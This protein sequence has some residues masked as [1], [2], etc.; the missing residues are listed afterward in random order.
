MH[1]PPGDLPSYPLQRV[2]SQGFRDECAVPLHK[3]GNSR[4]TAERI[5]ESMADV[6]GGLSELQ[7]TSNFFNDMKPS[8]RSGGSSLFRNLN[9][10]AEPTTREIR[11]A[12]SDAFFKQTYTSGQ[13]SARPL[14]LGSYNKND[15]ESLE[16]YR[17]DHDLD[18]ESSVDG[19]SIQKHTILNDDFSEEDELDDDYSS[20]NEE[21]SSSDDEDREEF[22]RK[23]RKELKL[24]CKNPVPN[25]RSWLGF[26]GR[27]FLLLFILVGILSSVAYVYIDD[28]IKVQDILSQVST[29]HPQRKY[30]QMPQDVKEIS[31]RM[32]RLERQ[33]TQ[34]SENSRQSS[35]D[36]L[37]LN[38]Q[39]QV[40][41]ENIETLKLAAQDHSQQLSSSNSQTNEFDQMLKA[42]E[43]KVD[44]ASKAL[45][46]INVDDSIATNGIIITLA[47]NID[48]AGHQVDE[49]SKRLSK[50]EEAQSIDDAVS[51]ALDKI[52]PSRLIVS[53]NATTG[54]F[55]A[56][57][58]FWKYI[59][60]QVSELQSGSQHSGHNKQE[61]LA[62]N[63]KI[64]EEYLSSYNNEYSAAVVPKDVI[65]EMI[66]KELSYL[67][68]ETSDTLASMEKKLQKSV[69]ENL[70]NHI[71]LSDGQDHA[72]PTELNLLIRTALHRYISHTISKPDFADLASG[73]KVIPSLTSHSYDWKDGLPLRERTVHK[74]L[75]VLGFGRMKVNRPS[76]AFSSDIRLGNCWPFNGPTGQ[77]AIDMGK[78]VKL[79]DVGVVHVR[80]DQTPNPKS[81]PRKIS[82][83]AQVLDPE[84][85]SNIAT[86]VR[87]SE[88]AT[89]PEEYVKFMS[90]EYDLMDDD[91]FQVFPVPQYIQNLNLA[92][93]KV[94]FDVESNWGNDE[95]TCLYRLR[96]FGELTEETSDVTVDSAGATTA[97]FPSVN[98]EEAE[99]LESETATPVDSEE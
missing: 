62:E 26:F 43:L 12:D 58:E 56:P 75:G 9:P 60:T 32:L 98:D 67:R 16:S 33:F 19:S 25:R 79:Q 39:L 2:T 89:F 49:L 73:A 87:Q 31:E 8:N 50:L 27:V 71:P 68:T 45:G 36:I 7:R 95:F 82:V 38:S 54:E 51:E 81:A 94:A 18:S 22:Q 97:E 90:L 29:W 6:P 84:L 35:E 85:R 93:S 61:F 17:G 41:L 78:S 11:H 44:Q 28:W 70:S 74:V 88:I 57:L 3:T 99:S 64:I 63:K 24:L 15:E 34:L 48:S 76:T 92:A 96:V 13:Y 91:E 86:L 30:Q 21:E 53:F 69:Q 4:Y 80:M 52:L 23:A 66:Y 83:Y 40:V 55:T 37:G 65:K 10:N 20:G 77:I 5:A 47:S 72:L 42:I 14:T 46:Q 59:S 1:G